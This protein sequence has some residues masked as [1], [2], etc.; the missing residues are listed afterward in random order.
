MKNDLY[1]GSV[2]IICGF[3]YLYYKLTKTEESAENIF[4]KTGNI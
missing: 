4:K 3:T 1:F 2:M